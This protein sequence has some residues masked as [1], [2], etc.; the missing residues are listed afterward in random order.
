MP[1][2]CALSLNHK[3]TA[4]ELADSTTVIMS[5]KV[6]LMKKKNYSY[7]NNLNSYFNGLLLNIGKNV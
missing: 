6:H 7:M 3:V 2:L 4:S 5:S 1:D